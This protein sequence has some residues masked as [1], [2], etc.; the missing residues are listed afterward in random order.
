MSRCNTTDARPP[1]QAKLIANTKRPPTDWLS[2][3]LHRIKPLAAF[4]TIAKAAATIR[5][6]SGCFLDAIILGRRRRPLLVGPVRVGFIGLMTADHTTGN[7]SNF[8]MAREVTSNAA[9]DC[10]LDASLRLGGGRKRD[11]EGGDADDESLHDDV[12]A[13]NFPRQFV[14]ALL[15]PRRRRR[16]RLPRR[17]G[18]SS[19]V[20]PRLGGPESKNLRPCVPPAQEHSG[21]REDAAYRSSCRRS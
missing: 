8:A 16:R 7:R 21:P 2:L 17:P 1:L 12:L 5:A 10:P 11:A 3:S 9:D 20:D 19:R 15:V 4:D 13:L 14:T 18:P 6:E